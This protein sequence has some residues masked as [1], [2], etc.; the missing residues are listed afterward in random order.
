[1]DQEILVDGVPVRESAFVNALRANDKHSAA[2]LVRQLIKDTRGGTSHLGLVLL[3]RAFRG[4]ILGYLR[5]IWFPD[6]PDTAAEVWNDVLLR[7]HTRIGD[8][9]PSRSGFLTWLFNQARWAAL[10][11]RR[12]QR[13]LEDRMSGEE[14]PDQAD[15]AVEMPHIWTNTEAAAF[16]RAWKGLTTTER[17]LL[18][19]RFI[20]GYG[21]V[22]IAR[23]QLAGK[24]PEEHVRVYVSRA[25]RQF[26]RLLDEEEF[27]YEA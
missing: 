15:E 24:I 20:D 21:H 9:D 7:V 22:E 18:R 8:F 13:R 2:L 5:S 23:N 4:L 19:A 14:I 26:K 17:N 1:M 27:P 6:D 12:K 16:R 3:S 10:D 25:V 11:T